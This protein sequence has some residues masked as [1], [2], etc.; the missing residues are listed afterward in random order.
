[1]GKVVKAFATCYIL[2]EE[3]IQQCG[4]HK[5]WTLKKKL[6][7]K[8]SFFYPDMNFG[9]ERFAVTREAGLFTSPRP[10]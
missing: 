5:M 8:V 6:F 1:M 9:N 4:V 3:S 7:I 10:Q 2:K